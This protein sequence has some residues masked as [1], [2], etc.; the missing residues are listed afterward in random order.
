MYTLLQGALGLEDRR[1]ELCH[2]EDLM[3]GLGWRFFGIYLEGLLYTWRRLLFDVGL[4]ILEVYI[5]C[6]SF[7]MLSLE[8]FATC[9]RP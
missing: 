9:W 3:F 8:E 6:P 2:V 1:G 4:V 7:T 5:R